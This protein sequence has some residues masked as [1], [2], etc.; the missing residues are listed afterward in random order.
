[1]S[2]SFHLRLSFYCSLLIKL[3]YVIKQIKSISIKVLRCSICVLSAIL[4]GWHIHELWGL[5]ISS[6]LSGRCRNFPTWKAKSLTRCLY[7]KENPFSFSKRFSGIQFFPI[8]DTPKLWCSFQ[9][10]RNE[11]RWF[12]RAPWLL[13]RIQRREEGLKFRTGPVQQQSIQFQERRIELAEQ[14]GRA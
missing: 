3:L 13:K 4:F 6:S 1:M 14:W 8:S 7:W 11:N 9:S 5:S 10:G 2:F 12:P